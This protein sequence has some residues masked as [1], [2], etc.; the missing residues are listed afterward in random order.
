MANTAFVCG[1]YECVNSSNKHVLVQG[2]TL[3]CCE[4]KLLFQGMAISFKDAVS[5]EQSPSCE[6]YS[7]SASQEIAAFYGTRAFITVFTQAS[8][9]LYSEPD[10]SSRHPSALFT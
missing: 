9:R 6:A 8:Y 1:M 2:I 3:I 7:C 5:K 10:E 4:T